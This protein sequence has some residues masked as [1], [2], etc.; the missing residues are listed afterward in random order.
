M[1]P[2]IDAQI[3]TTDTRMRNSQQQIPRAKLRIRHVLQA[4]V[5]RTM[6][7]QRKHQTSPVYPADFVTQ[8]L[9]SGRLVAV[10]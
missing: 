8:A 3:G 9:P 1:V 10:P 5:L 7:D 2:V 6:V 4:K